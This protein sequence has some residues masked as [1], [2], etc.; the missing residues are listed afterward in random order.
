MAEVAKQAPATGPN[1]KVTQTPAIYCTG[2]GDCPAG[3]CDPTA[4]ECV[5]TPCNAGNNVKNTNTD[6]PVCQTCTGNGNTTCVAPDTSVGG[7]GN[8]CISAGL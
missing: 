1:D 5:G 7:A 2:D 8:T 4:H 6:C 3:T